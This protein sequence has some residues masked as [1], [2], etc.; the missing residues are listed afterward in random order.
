MLK[1]ARIAHERNQLGRET[2]DGIRRARGAGN[3]ERVARLK[4]EAR[5]EKARWKR[6]EGKELTPKEHK[7]YV[8]WCQENRA[9]H[10]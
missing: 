10:G 7:V 1:K 9:A 5:I 4:R 6:H 2:A 8:E 3:T